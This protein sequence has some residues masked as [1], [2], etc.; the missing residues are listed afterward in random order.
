MNESISLKSQSMSKSVFFLLWIGIN[1][2]VWVLMSALSQSI[3]LFRLSN[4]FTYIAFFVFGSA[5]GISQWLLLKQRF[6]M[7]RYEWL[8]ASTI[9][10][11]LGMVASVWTLVLDRY[12]VRHSPVSPMLLWDPLIG[13]A[14]FGLALGICQGI[15]WRPRLDRIMVWIV[16]NVLGWSLGMFS[17]QFIVFFLFDIVDLRSTTSFYTIFQVAFAAIVTGIALVWFLREQHD[18]D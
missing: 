10:F 11:T 7:A 3:G 8:I 12:I 6:T 15:V 13:G 17:P 1:V 5:M 4:T 14:L 9:G 16:V 18:L 2:G